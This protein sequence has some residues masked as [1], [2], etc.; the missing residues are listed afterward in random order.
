MKY[1]CIN[2]CGVKE[3]DKKIFLKLD[4]QFLERDY[5]TWYNDGECVLLVYVTL[6][7][8]KLLLKLSSIPE[9]L[10]IVMLCGIKSM[11]VLITKCRA[12]Q[13]NFLR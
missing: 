8:K 10:K 4:S 5:I 7:R 13:R 11:D 6:T 9:N 3:I 1:Y 2:Y 12:I